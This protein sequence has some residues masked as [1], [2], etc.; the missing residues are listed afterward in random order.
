MSKKR[1]SRNSKKTLKALQQKR[2]NA[3]LGGVFARAADR[4]KRFREK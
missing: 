1:A 3:R 4:R 2:Q